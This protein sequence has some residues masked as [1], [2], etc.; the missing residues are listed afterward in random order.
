M[1]V[2]D[3]TEAVGAGKSSVYRTINQQTNFGAVFRKRKSKRGRKRKTTPRTD[4]FLVHNST[5]HPYKTSKDLQR[6][7]LAIGMSVDSPTIQRR[8][9]EAEKFARKPIEKQLL[10]PAMKKNVSIGS[11][12][13][14]AGLYKIERRLYSDDAKRLLVMLVSFIKILLH[15]I[16][17]R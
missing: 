9:I 1:T 3:I 16:L 13:I 15:A 14:S 2:R 17:L 12:N 7:L 5:M 8:L 10:T 6:E 11:G 4:K